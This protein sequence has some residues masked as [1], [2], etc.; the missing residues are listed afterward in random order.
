MAHLKWNDCF[1]Y[2]Q[3]YHLN[4]FKFI[5]KSPEVLYE[6]YYK[7]DSL[8]YFR[9]DKVYAKSCYKFIYKYRDEDGNLKAKGF[10]DSYYTYSFNQDVAYIL[11]KQMEEI[12]NNTL[13]KNE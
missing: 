4:D 13:I 5:C 1:D 11:I 6:L 12:V 8:G 2:L 7:D 10:S 9:I 3:E